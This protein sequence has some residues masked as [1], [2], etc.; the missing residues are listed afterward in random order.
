M[1]RET[2]NTINRLIRNA[3]LS[4]LLLVL[5]LAGCATIPTPTQSERRGETGSLGICADFFA[6]LDQ[7]IEASEVL[8]PGV[9]RV[10]GYPYLRVNRFLASFR[11]EAD[12]GAAFAAW[13]DRLQELDREA[14]TYE[15]ANLPAPIGN[16][17]E[18]ALDKAEIGNRV[19]ACGDLLKDADFRDG[20]H[21]D[22][23]R[24]RVSVPDE[25]IGLRRILGVYPLTGLFVSH[26]VSK[27]HDEVRQ[28]FSVEPPVD[29]RTIRYVPGRRGDVGSAAQIFASAKRDALGIPVYSPEELETLFRRYAPIWEI[30]F[31]GDYDRIGA[32]AWSDEG[33][34]EIHTGEP[35][36]YT[37]LS[38][39]RFG[40][41]VLT[42][43]NYIIWF[44]CRPKEGALDIYG[45][46]LDGV[47]YR[48]TLD[49]DGEPLLYETMHNCG[50]YYKAYPTARLRVRGEIDYAE[51]P[52][53]LQAPD[54]DSSQQFVTLAMES[55]THFVQHV[56]PRSREARP[57]ATAYSMADYNQ[58]RSL[59]YVKGAR[60]S[61]FSE[62]SI[63]PESERLER[64]ILWPMGVLS[65]GGMRQW[66]RHAVAFLGER[67]FDDPFFMDKMYT[68]PDFCSF[69]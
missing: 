32:P 15:A 65:P 8:D 37:L 4:T 38:F 60:R 62:D 10:D 6:S 25:Y 9:Y 47:N 27:W 61:M 13:I 45:G 21:R 29:W 23:L 18:S 16:G 59:P 24:N 43:L 63:V 39:T 35:V 55:R 67:Q 20:E 66:G 46:L 2:I 22:A 58:L 30:Q 31:E 44:P 48:V 42:Q 53:I 17:S 36:T 40:N 69:K 51:P 41:D 54:L 3:V 12:D 64:F 50:C 7:R 52:L 1:R 19:A 33:V 57:E 5:F 56:Y 28:R 68:R 34:L 26:G 11:E 49:R 14:R